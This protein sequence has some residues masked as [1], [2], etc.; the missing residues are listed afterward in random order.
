MKIIKVIF[1]D[2]DGVVN[3]EET[4]KRTKGGILGID[5]YLVSIFNRIIFATDA[6]IVLSS[7][8]RHSKEGRDEV[9]QQIMDFIDVTP[10]MPLLGGSETME[11]GKEI[12][13]W[14]DKHPEVEKYAILD[15]DSDFLPDQP[16]FKT[17]WK[18]GLTEEIAK[19]VIKHLNN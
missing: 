15:D 5:P 2:I 10:R 13:A 1:L 11:R 3:S 16:L 12:K 7:S 9:R 8:W 17:T 6:K 4:L 18:K 14:L 19:E